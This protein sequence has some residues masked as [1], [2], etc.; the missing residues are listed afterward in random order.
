M[1]AAV[2]PEVK[3]VAG[4]GTYDTAHSIDLARAHAELEGLDGLLVV[5]PYYS[6][7]SQA[8]VIAHTTAIADATDLP[9]M[10]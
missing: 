1:R 5:T 8:G 2:G 9:V 4:V 10:L 3:V 7:P 6:K